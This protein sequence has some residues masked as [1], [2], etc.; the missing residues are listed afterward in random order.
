[1]KILFFVR[2]F[3]PHIG[4]V[5]KHTYEIGRRLI[6]EGNKL[7]VITEQY[8]VTLPQKE[9][10][11][12]FTIYRIP[13]SQGKLKKYHVWF[14]LLKHLNLLFQ[15]NIIHCHDI[16]FWYLPFRFLFLRKKVFTTFHGYEANTIPGI[17]AK[18]MHKIAEKLSFGNICVGVFLEKWYGTKATIITYGGVDSVGGAWDVVHRGKNKNIYA[19]FVGRLE[20]ETGIMTYLETLV[21]LKKKEE[22]IVLTILGD[23]AQREQAEVLVK[24][25]KLSVTFVGFVSDINPYL[26]KADIVFTSRYLGILEA[27]AKQKLVFAA[28]N[29][30]IKKDYLIMTPFADLIIIGKSA[31]DLSVKLMQYIDNKD[32]FASR[33]EK[34]YEWA[35]HQTWDMLVYTYH[36]LWSLTV[37]SNSKGD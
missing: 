18:W 4:G 31:K 10:Y 19:V 33:I 13:V 8:D 28:Y 25:H 6:E 1:M 23:G 27:F 17:K 22:K 30:A 36:K 20:E 11:Q 26:E 12:G 9:I 16:F 37:H 15:S 5:E 32:K 7:I 24:K 3:Y 2:L 35:Q 34:A 29:N 14:W 21:L